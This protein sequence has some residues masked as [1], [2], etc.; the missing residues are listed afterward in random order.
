MID[1]YAPWEPWQPQVGDWVR[2]RISPECV[3]LTCGGPG[4]SGKGKRLKGKGE[5]PV[6]VVEQINS[7]SFTSHVPGCFHEGSVGHRFYVA[8]DEKCAGWAAAIELERLE[9]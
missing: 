5:G 9:E 2:V 3:C 7:L 1:P 4:H 6:G 8:V